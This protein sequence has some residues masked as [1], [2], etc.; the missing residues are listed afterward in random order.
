MVLLLIWNQNSPCKGFFNNCYFINEFSN[1]EFSKGHHAVISV[2]FKKVL[3]FYRSNL[4]AI[5][6]MPSA[7]IEKMRRSDIFRSIQEFALKILQRSML[8]LSSL[9]HGG[10]LFITEDTVKVLLERECHKYGPPEM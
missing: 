4:S 2:Y 1:G 3:L 8:S 6:K 7:R 9:R 10:S 5:T